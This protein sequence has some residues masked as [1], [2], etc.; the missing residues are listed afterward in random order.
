MQYCSLYCEAIAIAPL[1]HS[2][3][4]AETHPVSPQPGYSDARTSV[5]APRTRPAAR[6]AA[7]ADSLML[8]VSRGPDCSRVIWALAMIAVQ[9][10]I[11][12]RMKARVVTLLV[13]I[14]GGCAHRHAAP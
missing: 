13:L 8:D 14:V 5:T 1:Q 11:G 3:L 4:L 12:S 7:C 6:T 10:Y 9:V 2:R